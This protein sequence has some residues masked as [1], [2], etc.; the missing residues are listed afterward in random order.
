MVYFTKLMK[1]SIQFLWRRF[2]SDK[3]ILKSHGIGDF[4]ST[5]IDFVI[6]DKRA[7]KNKI[8]IEKDAYLKNE[9]CYTSKKCI[10]S[11]ITCF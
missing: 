1:K 11:K 8:I 5:C 3:A 4:L 2:F 7:C 10:G 6:D 9:D